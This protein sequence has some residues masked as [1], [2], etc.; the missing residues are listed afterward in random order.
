[1]ADADLLREPLH[2]VAS[3]IERR[4]VSPVEL[5]EQSLAAIERANPTGNAFRIVLSERAL[6]AARRAESE[7]TS[8]TY[9]GALH[10]VPI[11][12]KDLMDIAGETSPAGSTVLA[13][14]VAQH[15]SEVVR[16]FDDAGAIITGKTCSKPLESRV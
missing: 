5:T 15:D 10:G 2:A 8:G 9:R 11:A 13:D 7:I 4:E 14:R 1:M 12:V 6:A 3:L 16:L